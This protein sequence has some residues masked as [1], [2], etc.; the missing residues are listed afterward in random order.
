[1]N[2]ISVWLAGQGLSAG[3]L[4]A[5][6]MARYLVVRRQVRSNLRSPRALVALLRFLRGLGVTPLPAVVV[7][8]GADEVLAARFGQYLSVQ[9]GLAAATVCSYLSQ[10]APFLAWHAGQPGARWASLTSGEVERFIVGRAA[11]QRPRSVQVGLNAIRALL[12]W[13]WLEGLAPS[14][15]AD[16]I[17]PVAAKASTALPQALTPAQVSDLRSGLSDD[18]AAR[19]RDDA[20]VALMWRM[21]LRAGEVAACA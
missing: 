17:G 14:G 10:V 6:T 12:R 1:M 19:V 18:G 16:A 8:T 5:E 20:M 2:D 7:P 13:M 4:S 11:G 9:K 3:D 15:L 21:G